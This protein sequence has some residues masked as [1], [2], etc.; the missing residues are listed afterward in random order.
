MRPASRHQ[1]RWVSTVVSLTKATEDKGAAQ[2]LRGKTLVEAPSSPQSAGALTALSVHD[3]HEGVGTVV[4]LDGRHVLPLLTL[5][6]RHVCCRLLSANVTC[7][8][9]H[10]DVVSG[11]ELGVRPLGES[12]GKAVIVVKIVIRVVLEEGGGRT[13]PSLCDITPSECCRAGCL[14]VIE[15]Q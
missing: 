7:T 8:L 9:A 11:F 2:T 1:F 5:P 15:Q 13:M 10:H 4:L 3:R 6:E 12:T 14:V